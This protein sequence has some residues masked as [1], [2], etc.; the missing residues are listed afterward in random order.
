V[1][2]LRNIRKLVGIYEFWLARFRVAPMSSRSRS[3]VIRHVPRKRRRAFRRRLAQACY[4]TRGFVAAACALA[5][6]GSRVKQVAEATEMFGPP[7]AGFKG[8]PQ[9]GAAVAIRN[10]RSTRCGPPH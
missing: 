2:G 8:V 6:P 3:K 7:L 9:C 1:T 10:F 4:S 5:V